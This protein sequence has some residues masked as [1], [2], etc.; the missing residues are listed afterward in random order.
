MSLWMLAWFVQTTIPCLLG[1]N[2][3]QFYGRDELAATD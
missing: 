2:H 3:D 1:A